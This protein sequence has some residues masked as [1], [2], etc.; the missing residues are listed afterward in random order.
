MNLRSSEKLR[1]SGVDFIIKSGRTLLYPIYKSTYERGDGFNSA[2]STPNSTRDHVIIWFKD[3]SRSI[4]YLES[5]RDIDI[6]KLAYYGFSWGSWM[7]SIFLALEERIKVSIF[8][9]G[10]FFPIK[11][12]P[13]VDQIN[14]VPRVT[15]PTLML[16]GRYDYLLPLE[17]LQIPMFRLLGTPEE[18]KRHK[19]YDTDHFIPRNE[20]IKETLN[21]LDR[22]L[23]PVIR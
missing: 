22:Y 11:V 8:Y 3:L 13:E 15:I 17:A 20:R 10:G 7:G 6:D 1:I 12:P 14:F 19:I 18:H 21:W 2:T 23:G 9:V 5:R 16:N 4:D